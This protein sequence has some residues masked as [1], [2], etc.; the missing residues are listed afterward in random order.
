MINLKIKNGLYFFV[1]K[2]I[3]YSLFKNEIMQSII[4]DIWFKFTQKNNKFYNFEL[5]VTLRK[6]KKNIEAI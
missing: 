2:I 5:I 1:N 4:F 6:Q 3:D